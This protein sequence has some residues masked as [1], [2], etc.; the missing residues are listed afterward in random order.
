MNGPP[1]LD[2]HV[3][4][5]FSDG[6]RSPMDVF[7]LAQ[8]ANVTA[9]AITDHDTVD[10]IPEAL[11]ASRAMGV[12][13]IPGIEISSRYGE[14]ELHVLGYFL[15]WQD[16]ALRKQL[17]GLKETRHVR[18]PQIIEKL[19]ALG[20]DITYDEVRVL[21]GDA[22]IG[23][24]HI[25]RVLMQKG[26]VHSAKEAFDRYLAEGAAAYV[27]RDLPGPEQ[28]IALIRAAKGAAVLAHPVWLERV[29]EGIQRLCSRLKEAG[30]QGIEAHYS[31]HSPDQTSEYLETARRLDLLVTGGSDFHGATKPDIEVGVGR[32]GLTVPT[33]LLEPLRK[34][35][36]H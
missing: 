25:A 23:R 3:H 21:A 15:D 9:M 7:T 2:L 8:K 35:A 29:G 4:T 13:L 5:T 1:R 24:P 33:K 19:R 30:L 14:T 20:M 27:P 16:A 22:S 36:G 34:A 26:Y 18:N 6:S 11:A 10:G 32:G 31:T 12:A 17:D 28:A